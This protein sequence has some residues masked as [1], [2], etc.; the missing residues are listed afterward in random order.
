MLSEAPEVGDF[1][2]KPPPGRGLVAEAGEG[3]D[4]GATGG[5]SR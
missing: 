5:S 3:R 1:L 2:E 4:K